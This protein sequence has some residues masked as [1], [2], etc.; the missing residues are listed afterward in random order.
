MDPA[1]ADALLDRPTDPMNPDPASGAAASDRR[2]GAPRL[3]DAGFGWAV[4]PQD[5]NP[6]GFRPNET[7]STGVGKYGGSPLFAATY[8]FPDSV[9]ASRMKSIGDRRAALDEA[10]QRFNPMAGVEDVNAPEY[11]D[12]FGR[13]VMDDIHGYMGSVIDQWGEEEGY[14]R[15]M[16]GSTPEGAGIQQRA[17]HWTT[18]ARQINQATKS[19]DAVIEGAKT[20]ALQVSPELYRQAEELRYKLGQRAGQNDPE[21]LAKTMQTFN[22]NVSLVDQLAKDKVIDM[23]KAAGTVNKVYELV[24]KGDPAFDRRFSTLKGKKTV[25]YTSIIDSLTDSYYQQYQGDLSRDEVRSMIASMAPQLYEED[26]KRNQYSLP[27]SKSSSASEKEK[28][29]DSLYQADAT[30]LP[31]SINAEVVDMAGDAVM[32]PGGNEQYMPTIN[33]MAFVGDQGRVAPAHNFRDGN[34][35]VFMHPERLMNVG[36]EL[37]IVG[38]QTGMPRTQAEKEEIARKWNISVDDFNEQTSAA[39][40]DPNSIESQAVF[41][42]FGLLKDEMVPLSGQNESLLKQLLDIDLDRAKDAMG[43]RPRPNEKSDATEQVKSSKENAPSESRKQQGA[44]VSITTKSEYD[45]LPIGAKY[46]FNGKEGTKRR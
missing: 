22:A 46:I 31:Q 30:A 16:S 15:L 24:Q 12:S 28:R 21:E 32:T 10:M 37:M 33:L 9:V 2:R 41:E 19:A 3:T 36:G 38:K 27:K 13:G 1:T 34:R 6:N 42:R 18:V 35:T 14:R 20:G 7:R 4:G 5:F 17:H 26:I 40:A 29:K 11:R 39:M 23:M 44:A 45:A 8:A 25:D 43:Y